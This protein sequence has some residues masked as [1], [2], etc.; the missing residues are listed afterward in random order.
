MIIRP[1]TREDLKAVDGEAPAKTTRAL[2]AVEG[3]EV[4]AIWGIY[5]QNSR[6]VLFS[7]LSP[8]FKA[9]KRNFIVGIES[10]R[11]LLASRPWMPV[12]AEADPDIPGSDV[13]L[14]HMGFDH[15]FGRVY[16][17]HGSKPLPQ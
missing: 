9:C 1:A 3:E 15:V 4:I 12:I 2:A 16:Q 13:L 7:S 8:K 14:K 10:V 11:Q 5:P 6:Y 17:W